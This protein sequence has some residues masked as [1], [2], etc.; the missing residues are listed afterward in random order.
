MHVPGPAGPDPARRQADATPRDTRPRH[1]SPQAPTPAGDSI[2][3]STA[4][5]ELP[6]LQDILREANADRARRIAE[7]KA[8]LE[9][10]AFDTEDAF[11]A[12]ARGIRGEPL[13]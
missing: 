3:L 13:D 10:G 7:L 11:V 6:R 2:E 4:A 12:A 9:A 8:Q 5:R 1:A